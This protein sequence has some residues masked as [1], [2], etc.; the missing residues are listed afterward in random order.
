M[1]RVQAVIR[2]ERFD[3]VQAALQAA[4]FSGLMVHDVRG[5]GAEGTPTGEYRGVAFSMTVRH[6]LL[7]DILVD[8]EEVEVVC[9]TIKAAASQGNP[10]DGM[11]MLLDV[12]GVIP[13]R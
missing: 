12:E 3:D 5:H 13:F 9:T 10:G 11:I 2:P 6:K 4:G 1:K 7:I 8:D